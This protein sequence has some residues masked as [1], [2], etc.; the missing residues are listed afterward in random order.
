M[1]SGLTLRGIAETRRAAALLDHR[2]IVSRYE[3]NI[4]YGIDALAN[5]AGGQARTLVIPI[6]KSWMGVLGLFRP[7]KE[8][9]EPINKSM[10]RAPWGRW[11]SEVFSRV[12]AGCSSTLGIASRRSL[13]NRVSAA[14]SRR[15]NHGCGMRIMNAHPISGA[16]RFGRSQAVA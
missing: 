5:A 8:W 7:S 1:G 16:S 2:R 14:N 6:R 15:D 9:A 4:W 3:P 12:R 10:A 13:A 11:S